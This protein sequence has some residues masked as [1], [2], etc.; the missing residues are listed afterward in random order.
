MPRWRI[1]VVEWLASYRMI[2]FEQ[3]KQKM[4]QYFDDN[5]GA[6]VVLICFCGQ[7]TFAGHLVYKNIYQSLQPGSSLAK[8]FS[9]NLDGVNS[10]LDQNNTEH[11]E[12]TIPRGH[13]LFFSQRKQAYEI[14]QV[15]IVSRRNSN[16]HVVYNI[17]WSDG[18]ETVFIFWKNGEAEVITKQNN[19]E[20]ILDK[21][22]YKFDSKGRL[23][24]TSSIGSYSV[25]PEF[26]PTAN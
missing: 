25:F 19:S 21:G 13:A 7:L 10:S 17:S 1:I 4:L 24:V 8:N 12:I 11:S 2:T 20:S 26:I 15:D 9:R 14:Y 6:L 16:G 23:V 3:W 5:H 18:V 22:S